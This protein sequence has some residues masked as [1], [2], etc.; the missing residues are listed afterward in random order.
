MHT[1]IDETGSFSGFGIPKSLSLIGALVV[2]GTRLA[3]LEKAYLKRRVDLPKHN[4]EVKGRLLDEAQILSLTR[5][6][7]EN[8]AIFKATAVDFAYHSEAGLTTFKKGQAEKITGGLTDEHEE[9]LKKQMWEFRRRF[10]SYSLPLVVQTILTFQFLPAVLEMSMMYFST[11]RPQELGAFHWVVDAKGNMDTP[12]DWENWWSKMVLPFTETRGYSKPLRELPIGDYSHMKR[13]ETP[14][15]PF[16]RKMAR[17]KEDDNRPAYNLK[18]IFDEDF[19][20]SKEPVPGL[21]LV[22]IVT[23]AT[24]RA[25]VGNLRKEGW[26]EIPTLMI[27]QNPQYIDF[28][29]LGADPMPKDKVPYAD[30]EKHFRSGGRI[31]LPA[32]LRNKDW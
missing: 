25:L 12:I 31:M 24:R 23:N 10:E 4:G 7:R 1:F 32:E 5:L 20:F 9:A 29:I 11:R 27:H 2:P 13:F 30:V 21:E 8:S 14:I 26:N 22:D 16:Q 28:S 15:T 19:K 3:K 17:R 18:M 6:L